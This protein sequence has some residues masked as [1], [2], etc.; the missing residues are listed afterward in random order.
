L[1][2]RTTLAGVIALC[3]TIT[4]LGAGEARAA[5]GLVAAYGFDEGT[6]T[7]L[8]D[9]SGS[10]NGGQAAGTT[11]ATGGRFGSALSFDGASSIVSVADSASLHLTTGMTLEA[12]VNPT[13][14]GT[15]GT[16]WRTVVFKQTPSG[17]AYS[18]YA[19]N[20]G[21]R[22]TGQVN[23][24]GEQNAAGAAQL[25]LNA[26][27]HLATTYDGAALRLFVNG[28]E[29]AARTQTGSIAGSTG[30]LRIGGNAVWG[31]Y[32]KGLIDE[33][34]V[35][36]R[37]LS[38]SEI[39]A[40]MA[41]PMTQ[42]GD[43][44]PPSARITSPAPGASVSGNVTVTADATDDRAVAGVQFQVDGAAIGGE[45]TSA[46]YTAAWNA[47]APGSHTLT[48]VARDSAGN[49]ATS[50]PVTVTVPGSTTPQFVN[51]RV[52]IGLDEPTAITF[53]PDGRMLIAERDG[54]VWV[55]AAGAS[56]VSPTPFLQIPSIATDNERGLLGIT[57]DPAFAQ[58]GYVYAYYTHDSLHNRVSR[59]TAT[60]N[61]ASAASETVI[62]QNPAAAG[63]WHQGGDVHFGTDGDLYISVG[64]HL[65]SDTAQQLTSYNGKI[66]RV[67]RDGVAPTDNPFYDGAGPNLD[68]IWVRGLRNPFRFAID[69]VSGRVIIGDVGENLWEEVD[70]GVPGANYGWPVC[71]GTCSTAGMTNPAYTYKHNG[72]DAS[73][74]AGFVYRGSQF[75]AD[76]AGEFFFGDYAQNWIRRLT[77][78]ASGNVISVHNFEPPD[79][80]LDG[81]YGDIVDLAQGPDGS[82]WYVDA[83]PF[84]NEN[85]GAVRRIRNVNASNQPPTAVAAG[86]PTSGQAP[87]AVAFSSA[88]S[89]DPEGRPLTYRWDFGDG[90][91]STAA[92]PSHTY[93]TAGRYTA[94]VTTSD[95]TLE[96]VSNA[97][98][99]TAGSPPVPRITA[100]TDGRTFR[101]GDVITFSGDA[102]DPQDGTLP[103]SRLSWRIVFHH[104]THIHPVLDGATGSSGTVTIPT[105]GHSFRGDT[106]YEIV[107]TATDS[108]GIQASKSVTIRPAKA[109]L[110]IA[111]SPPGLTVNVDGVSGTAPSVNN[112]LIGFQYVL[113]APSPQG[114]YTF[115]G[116]SDGGARSHTVT[117]A[118][119][120]QTITARFTT[121][122]AGLVAAYGFDEGAGTTLSDVSGHGHPGTIA[123]PVWAAGHSG[124]ALSFD[125]VNDWVRVADHNELDL[126]TGMTLE[127]WVKP[128]ALGTTWRTV[129]FKEQAAHM[130]YALYAN[131]STG[132]PTAQAYVGGQ[133][134]AR[135]SAALAT[136]AWTHLAGSYDGSTVRLYVNGTQAATATASGPMTVSTG[137]LDL[138]GN[139]IWG[140]WF[141]GLIDDARVY[142]RALSPAEIQGDMAAPVGAG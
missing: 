139:G 39:Q 88:G 123:G 82:L 31:E 75:P 138:G 37:A 54:T 2:T 26:W 114:A 109:T 57:L 63:V 81:P 92:N 38:A 22:P 60:G 25:P 108:D 136:G 118:P 50:A 23:I 73:I 14:L 33:V 30:A 127:A 66:L 55:A 113:D 104:D 5:G 69:P 135:G 115:A 58:N 36:N 91:T 77:L 83:G 1:E 78:D 119:T 42:S 74:T 21:G 52:I 32:F 13:A 53:A 27:T 128:T 85:A 116:W 107:L 121:V 18:L 4:F 6:G 24:V 10:G 48:A 51:D 102:T 86:T 134:D 62:W 16:D 72:H 19:N 141:A 87:L 59:F 61:T 56:Q 100:P 125:G 12:W 131:T 99:I 80:S 112:E 110:T 103:P 93:T 120:D 97:V 70:L 29:V 9:A 95:G 45:D 122:R 7:A 90:T 98:T 41:T 129:L 130:T 35:Y 71:E 43:A 67:K 117:V 89:S 106:S 3:A 68:A 40:D 46:P 142:N 111:T 49:R 94:R 84:A 8:A 64:D 124:G 65:Q 126:T 137:P 20:G 96:T 44:T 101:A 28:T 105:S 47:T 76:Y 17:M 34:R 132:Q 133:R 15:T 140:E 11:W 79:G